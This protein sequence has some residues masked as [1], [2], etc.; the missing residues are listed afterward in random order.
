MPPSRIAAQRTR[1]RTVIGCKCLEMPFRVSDV[2]QPGTTSPI[3][4]APDLRA[5][6]RYIVRMGSRNWPRLPT[7][8][9]NDG[10]RA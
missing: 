4:I 5:L 3:L 9:G 1:H 7:F 8:G 6:L 2:T 10:L